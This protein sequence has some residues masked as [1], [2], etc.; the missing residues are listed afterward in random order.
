MMAELNE[1]Q[2]EAE[3]ALARSTKIK[4]DGETAETAFIPEFYG[5]KMEHTFR[6]KNR[7]GNMGIEKMWFYLS[8][9]ITEVTDIDDN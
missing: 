9:D 1:A 5:W 6:A 3:E 8:K 4:E 2:A 7:A